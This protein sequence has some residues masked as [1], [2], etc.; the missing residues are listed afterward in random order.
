MTL[1]PRTNNRRNPAASRCAILVAALLGFLIKPAH[2][3]EIIMDNTAGLPGVS[4][5]GAW[6]SSTYSPGYYGSNYI[7]DA[8]TGKGAKS[9]RFTPVIPAAG[10]YDV[11]LRWTSGP[12]RASNVPVD[13]A[14]AG[15]TDRLEV[16]QRTN[17][18]TWVLLGRYTFAA[19]N[20][21]SI[22]IS[23]AAT[24]G[25]VVADAV[26]FVPSGEMILDDASATGVTKFGSWTP[27]SATTPFYGSGYLHDG[28]AGKG[29]K[30][31][32][33]TP[34]I[35]ATR[36]YSV[37]IKWNSG[38]NRATNVPVRINHAGG[39]A[40]FTVN[41][42]AT[43]SG[44]WYYLGIF[45]FTAGTS[46]NIVI[47][48][49]GTDG[50]V[51]ADAV[52]IAPLLDLS[53]YTMT[54]SEEF[55]GPLSVSNWGPG[56]K[57]IAHTPYNGDFGDAWFGYDPVNGIN[58]YSIASGI[59]SIRAWFD[60]TKNHWRSG[61]LASVNRQGNGFS[62]QYGYF[63]ARMKLPAGT[64]TWPAFWLL[65]KGNLETPKTRVAEIDAIEFYGAQTTRIWLNTHIWNTDGTEAPGG[66][67]AV[68][69][70]NS[71]MTT[72]FHNYGVMVEPDVITWYVDGVQQWQVPTFPEAK[73]PLYI[74]VDYALGGG[75]GTSGVGNPSYTE[76][77]YIRAYS[78]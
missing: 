32:T 7:H 73:N 72:G 16:D 27:S 12:T 5:T 71:G 30:T 44:E 37:Q 31:V 24:D 55:D 28:N 35:P 78:K 52:R 54:F 60:T 42:R 13:V 66:S 34:D 25:H 59:L 19:G 15:G 67:A 75:W 39:S 57:W 36:S 76:I 18:G 74:L 3:I 69:F 43:G 38:S 53:G 9:V 58:P 48:N 65:S 64:G 56:T 63:E 10:R 40:Q 2:A 46:G 6:T 17:G 62:Q 61:L 70:V 29:S 20:S 26:R 11:Y 1:L 4:I 8:N 22:L 41:Q 33:F 47:S 51:V 77:D 50:Y 14:F 23:N 49:T 21:G 68:N 45:T